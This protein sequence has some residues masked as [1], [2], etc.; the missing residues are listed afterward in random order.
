MN[1][2]FWNVPHIGSGWVIGLIAIFHIMISHFAVGGGLYLPMAEQKALREGRQDWLDTLRSHSKFFLV[3]TGV[4]GT[5]SGVGIWFA[6]GLANPEATST[7][8]HNFVFAWAIEWVVFL[9]ELST[10]VVY[11]Y[12]WGRISNEL[13]IKVGY[14]YA[15]SSF[16][17]LVVINGILTFMLTPGDAWLAVAGTGREASRFWQ[18]FFNPTY[19]PSLFLR[20]AVC[21][22]LAGIWAL[23]TCSRIDGEA[24]PQLKTDLVRWSAKWLLPSFIAMPFILGWYLWLVPESQRA[25]LQLGMT[26]IGT[27]AF[28]QVTRVALIMVLTS[29]T[30]VGLVYFL[31]WRLPLSFGRAHA[32]AILLLGL[33]VTAAG[34]YSREMLRKPYVIGRHMY[35]NGVRVSEVA[36]F[37]RD[38]YL[39]QSPWVPANATVLQRGQIMFRGECMACHTADAYRSM[40]VLLE[41]RDREAISRLLAILHDS[42]PDSPYKAFMPPLVGTAEEV[43]ALGD[44]LESLARPAAPQAK[45]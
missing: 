26:T 23:V 11:Y 15:I 32:L 44:Y 6:I 3:L 43:T 16:L 5:V 18:A 31:A 21:V 33:V 8:I 42:K 41:G 35:S 29:A 25:L 13:H 34:E 38:G 20:S 14:A 45:D 36:R 24:R 37:N 7:L 2:P 28:T 4:F 17:T 12:T 39:P 10:I 27:G 9:V 40:K 19:W 22:S 1:Y 30:V